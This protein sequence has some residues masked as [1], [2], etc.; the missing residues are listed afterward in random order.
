[1]S[2]KKKALFGYILV[3]SVPLFL[4]GFYS[5]SQ[6]LKNIKQDYSKTMLQSVEFVNSIIYEKVRAMEFATEAIA[7]NVPFRKVLENYSEEN[8]FYQLELLTNITMFFDGME[9]FNNDI[10]KIN[11]FHQNDEL[12]DFRMIFFNK[13]LIENDPVYQ[14]ACEKNFNEVLWEAEHDY[15]DYNRLIY[16][17]N[18]EEKIKERVF[19]VYR[20]IMSLDYK[21]QI[22]IVQLDI[23][24]ANLLKGL[25][26][27]EKN[28][29]KA[30]WSYW[31]AAEKPYLE[32]T[33][34]PY[35]VISF[36]GR[37]KMA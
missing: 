4:L 32:T 35:F 13:R 10:F 33:S 36:S 31:T 2:L 6:T 8:N 23:K 29:M 12:Y 17:N 28:M 3:V 25:D 24:T 15:V 37:Y 27:L 19:S 7:S 21:R 20:K 1:M 11:V 30:S 34:V 26:N 16:K 22:G 14:K 9:N 18:T 5:Y